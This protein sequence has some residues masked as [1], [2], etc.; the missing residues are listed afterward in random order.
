MLWSTKRI[1]KIN[2][3]DRIHDAEYDN[4]RNYNPVMNITNRIKQY[5][6]NESTTS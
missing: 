3:N 5:Q 6:K 4:Y 1:N 2:Q